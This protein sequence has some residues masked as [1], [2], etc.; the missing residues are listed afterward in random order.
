M[1]KKPVSL[2]MNAEVHAAAKRRAKDLGMNSLA[3]YIEA[4]IGH[5]IA[6]GFSFQVTYA[7][8]KSPKFKAIP[9]A[10]TNARSSARGSR[11][12]TTTRSGKGRSSA[13]PN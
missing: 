6:E 11:R 8:K 4:L 9:Q 3:D 1:P 5:D 13:T 12:K 2:R 10:R 7:A